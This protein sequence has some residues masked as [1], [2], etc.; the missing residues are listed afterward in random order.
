VMWFTARHYRNIIFL[1]K[2][3]YFLFLL[4]TV[5]ASSTSLVI[6]QHSA[7]ALSDNIGVGLKP[8]TLRFSPISVIDLGVGLGF[9]YEYK[10]SGSSKLGLILPLNIILDNK[11]EELNTRASNQFDTYVYFTPGLKIYTG[12]PRKVNYAFGPSLMMGW[13]KNSDWRPV[14]NAFSAAATVNDYTV[15]RWRFGLLF[16]NYLNIQLTSKLNLGLE[17]GLGVQYVDIKKYSSQ[18]LDIEDK[19]KRFGIDATGQFTLTLGYQF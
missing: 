18:N 14:S 3:K 16:N 17:G 7:A 13:G 9:S 15:V 8:H 1:M 11:Q 4:S 10:F 12:A 6:G 5:L 2:L 19:A